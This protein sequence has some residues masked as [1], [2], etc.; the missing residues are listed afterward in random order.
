MKLEN[1]MQYSILELNDRTLLDKYSSPKILNYLA[2]YGLFDKNYS[3]HINSFNM[4]SWPFI[5]LNEK[6]NIP[7]IELM[8]Y[9]TSYYTEFAFYRNYIQTYK[10]YNTNT[11]YTF[12]YDKPMYFDPEKDKYFY[13]GYLANDL[14]I[15]DHKYTEVEIGFDYNKIRDVLCSKASTGDRIVINKMSTNHL[16]GPK[17]SYDN[18]WTLDGIYYDNIRDKLSKLSGKEYYD[19]C[20]RLIEYE[21]TILDSSGNNI[22]TYWEMGEDCPT[23][24]EKDFL[25]PATFKRIMRH[26]YPI[27]WD[28]TKHY[29]WED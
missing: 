29:E 5:T 4:V 10:W 24:S 28:C 17:W 16:G 15:T 11:A 13:I 22:I 18:G 25:N 19:Y 26:P 27:L 14:I 2:N 12:E 7:E 20:M 3:D 8:K 6:S 23:K 1:L 9:I 21:R